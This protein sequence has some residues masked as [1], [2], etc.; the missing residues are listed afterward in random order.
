MTTIAYQH[1]GRIGENRASRIA[2]VRYETLRPCAR[3][4]AYTPMTSGGMSPANSTTVL[5][6]QAAADWF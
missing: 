2:G 1:G 5:R 3:T 6:S 4:T